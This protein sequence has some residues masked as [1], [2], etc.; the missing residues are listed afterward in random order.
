[1]LLSWSGP[2]LL[3]PHG[4]QLASL[5]YP[6]NSSSKNTRLD[7][8][9]LLQGIFPNQR[10]NLSLPHCRRILYHLSHQGSPYWTRTKWGANQKWTTR[11]SQETVDLPQEGIEAQSCVDSWTGALRA[12]SSGWERRWRTRRE[13][14]KNKSL[15]KFGN[16]LE[17]LDVLGKAI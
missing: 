11:G 16:A 17:R 1:M 2:S 3:Q 7:S 13:D 15:G 14:T 9:S 12:I 5:L 6:Q 10:S 8:Q 4:L